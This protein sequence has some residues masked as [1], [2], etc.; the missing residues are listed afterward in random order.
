MKGLTDFLKNSYTSYH[1]CENAKQILLDNGFSPLYEQDDWALCEEGK[2]FV[3]RGGSLIAFTVGSLDDFYYKIVATHTDSPCLKLKDNPFLKG[4]IYTT[5]NVERYGGGL[6][7]SFFDRPLKLAGRLIVNDNGILTQ[8][9]VDSSY[10]L[11]IPSLAIHMNR[12][13]NDKF[14]VNVQVDACPLYSLTDADLDSAALLPEM[15]ENEVI[16]SDLYL[17]NA[18]MPYTFGKNDEFLASP[19]IDNL[20]C[21]FAALNAVLNSELSS[22]VCVAAFLDNEEVGSL[23][24]TGA[25]GDFF[26]NVLRR[27]A[28]SFRF[29]DN[30][31]YKA[32]ASSFM[33]SADNAHAVHPNHPEKADPSNKTKM[34]GGIVIKSHANK[35]YITDSLS[36]AVVR[37]VFGNANVKHQT[38]FNRS[39][40][41]SGSTLGA[42]MQRHASVRGADIGIAQLAMHSACECIA[43][44]D[45]NEMARGLTAFFAA[46][47]RFT[48]DG[49]LV[50]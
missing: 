1:A 36:A 21:T 26:E 38:F 7:Y 14:A 24:A 34:G 18:D 32:L 28:Y 41:A 10:L 11:T 37:T 16:A 30:E 12:E 20:A 40:M 35:A 17:V 19:R 8:K 29:D 39:D 46:T 42:A 27:I 6:W 23:T 22:G 44:S 31:Y 49:V 15:E 33:L 25:D 43:T 3:E 5:L 2:Y 9:T 13:A 48:K 45:Y 4:N 50:Q 47:I